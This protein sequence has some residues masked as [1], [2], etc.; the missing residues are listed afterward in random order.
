MSKSIQTLLILGALLLLS[1][2]SLPAE[3][4]K[5]GPEGLYRS[6]VDSLGDLDLDKAYRQLNA[7]IRDFPDS[8]EA[9]KARL[10]KVIISTVKLQSFD[11]LRRRYAD[12]MRE[13]MLNRDKKKLRDAHVEAT[14]KVVKSGKILVEDMKT[15]FEYAG[16][17]MSIEITKN[18]GDLKLLNE[19]YKPYKIIEVGFSPSPGEKEKIEK[20]QHSMSLNFVLGRLLTEDAKGKQVLKG[21]VDW[22]GCMTVVGDWLIHYAAVCKVGWIHPGMGK[23]VKDL[24]QAR[25]GYE[26]AR[27][28][29]EKVMNLTEKPNDK[30]KI[31]ARQR[32]KEIKGVLDG[33]E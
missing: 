17:P 19:I 10:L 4:K 2:D 13:A 21:D 3:R 28:C 9:E 6:A 23:R 31:R 5:K 12:G 15:L 26:T 33:M 25:S 27:Q 1:A 18:Y 16:R 24:K 30:R 11:M 29:F 14:D 8:G 20:L 32:I 7:A 22:V